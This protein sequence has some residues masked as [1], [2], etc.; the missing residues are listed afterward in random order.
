MRFTYGWAD[1]LVRFAILM[2]FAPLVFLLVSKGKWWLVLA[3]IW[4]A[5][6]FRGQSF[7]LAWQL[8]FNMGILIGYYWQPIRTRFRSL[9]FSHQ[10]LIKRTFLIS[11]LITF[12]AS[13]ANV[14]VLSLMFHLWG[15]GRLPP[16]L[17]HVAFTWGW[18]NHDVWIWDSKWT[19]APLRIVLF[20]VWFPTLF[21][22]VRRYEKQLVGI[23]HGILEML[24][25]N[26]LFVY[27]VHSIIVFTLKMYVIPSH[28][29][30]LQN[31]LI[32][33]LALVTL[34]IIVKLYV[35]YRP[36][37]ASAYHPL[38]GWRSN[39]AHSS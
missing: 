6:A 34:I 16:A 18:I 15:D 25:R 33:G 22:L 30:L 14:Y 26:S 38:I 20:F 23:S 32:T 8:L 10:Q 21:G 4:T 12:T 39:N 13:Y 29:S 24:G 5:W 36:A 1:F 19:M 9:S 11:A 27:S 31:F 37:L 17:Q 28:T 35:R 2:F 7:T 3:G